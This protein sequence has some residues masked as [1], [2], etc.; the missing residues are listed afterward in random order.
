MHDESY[1]FD[2]SVELYHDTEQKLHAYIAS[3]CCSG[4][5]YICKDLEEVKEHIHD[6]IDNYVDAIISFH[7]KEDK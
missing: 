1:F 2:I 7:F 5:D 6:Y 4:C 3:E